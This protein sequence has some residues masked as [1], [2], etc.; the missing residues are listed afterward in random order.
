MRVPAEEMFMDVVRRI[1]ASGGYPSPTA[2][3]VALAAPASRIRARNLNGRQ[4][5]WRAEVLRE[6]GWTHRDDF[7]DPE[8]IPAPSY[9]SYRKRRRRFQWQRPAVNSSPLAPLPG[10]NSAEC[11]RVGAPAR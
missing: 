7:R 8:T 4:V 10:A 9:E 5:Q 11:V 3:L 6:L 2:I 1:V